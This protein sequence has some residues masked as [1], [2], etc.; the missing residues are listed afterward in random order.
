MH[1]A[2]SPFDISRYYKQVSSMLNIARSIICLC[3]LS[4]LHSSSSVRRKGGKWR[5]ENSAHMTHVVVVVPFDVK[6]R[7]P[8]HWINI[9]LTCWANRLH[10]AYMEWQLAIGNSMFFAYVQTVKRNHPPTAWLSPGRC[11][12]L[13]CTV[14]FTW[15][16]AS[17]FF[18]I[19]WLLA[20]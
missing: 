3:T 1:I 20:Q 9:S 12:G 11:G 19:F 16:A 18:F 7:K 15:N 14:N 5:I 17:C 4:I 6:K 13:K 8:C 2:L 10:F